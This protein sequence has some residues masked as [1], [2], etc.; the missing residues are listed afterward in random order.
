MTDLLKM[1]VSELSESLIKKDI[2][3]TEITK[4]YLDNIQKNDDKRKRGD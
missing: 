4:A 1:K 2:S 3:S